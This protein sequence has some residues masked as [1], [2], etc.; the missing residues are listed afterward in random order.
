LRDEEGLTVLIVEQ[1]LDLIR[2]V[3]DNCI[4]MDKGNIVA[5]LT[6]DELQQPDIARKYLAI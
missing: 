6:P 1:N 5:K 2:A 4:V 3:A